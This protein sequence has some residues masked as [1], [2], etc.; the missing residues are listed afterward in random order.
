MELH[1]V[2]FLS[3]KTRIEVKSSIQYAQS[4]N[5][6]YRYFKPDYM[7]NFQ[8][9][10]FTFSVFEKTKIN[11]KKQHLIWGKFYQRLF[12]FFRTA[13]LQTEPMKMGDDINY[14][15]SIARY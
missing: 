15:G 11:A 12:R 14:W 1:F 3:S 7:A 2:R 6:E 13:P 10:K 4:K 9:T 8:E 5:N